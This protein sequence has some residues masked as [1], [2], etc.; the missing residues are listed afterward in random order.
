MTKLL[1][2]AFA[3]ALVAPPNAFAKEVTKLEI[4]GAAACASTTDQA[5]LQRL[6]GGTDGQTSAP[7]PALQPYYRLVYTIDAGEEKFQFTNYYLP[8]V[9]ALRVVDDRHMA[10]FHP[11]TPEYADLLGTVAAGLEPFPKP[12]IT[13]V[14]VGRKV[15]ADPASYA[16][17]LTIKGRSGYTEAS[18]WQR[19]RFATSAPSPWSRD[20]TILQFSPRSGYLF[21][22]GRF[23]K[24]PKQLAARVKAGR[25]LSTIT[26]VK[27]GL[28]AGGLATLALVLAGALLRRRL[29]PR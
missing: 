1:P 15:A 23:V 27:G 19:I 16:R 25:S 12:E 13:R 17:L 28:A 24:L 9:K 2:L 14:T 4:C 21:R 11:V 3:I 5:V 6:A 10:H 29:S 20:G 18:D 22:D 26:G 8:G 7:V